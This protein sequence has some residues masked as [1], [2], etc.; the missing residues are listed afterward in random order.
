MKNS[1]SMVVLAAATTVPVSAT[2][3]DLVGT[4][5]SVTD[6]SQ[7]ATAS[8]SNTRWV[9]DYGAVNRNTPTTGTTSYATGAGRALHY[10]RA[11]R[12]QIQRRPA[13]GGAHH[14]ATG[15]ERADGRQAFE[16]DSDL[17]PV[18]HPF[19]DGIAGGAQRPDRRILFSRCDGKEHPVAGGAFL[20]V[21]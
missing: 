18:G 4:T 13:T 8:T 20:A 5:A 10:A 2:W 19:I 14:Q 7:L 12:R 16:D 17:P 3:I 6:F 15:D 9:N 1:L 11:F 21:A